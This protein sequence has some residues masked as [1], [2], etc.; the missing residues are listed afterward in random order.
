MRV[1]SH[2]ADRTSRP[3]A[4]TA[5]PDGSQRARRRAA[6]GLAVAAV[7]AALLTW[8]VATGGALVAAFDE[9]LTRVTRSWADALGWPVDVAHA[10]GVATAPIRSSIVGAVVVVVLLLV[11]QRAAA[12]WVAL[13]GI[14]GVVT[15]ETVKLTMGRQR[16]P[17]AAQ[18]EDDLD[19]SFPSG[20][21]MVG[22]YLYLVIGLV[23]VQMGRAR[24]RGWLVGIGWSLVAIG[25]LIGASRLVLGV[26]WP[27]DLL[28][29]WAFGSVVALAS[30]LVLWWPLDRGWSRPGD[31]GVGQSAG[32]QRAPRT[33]APHQAPDQLP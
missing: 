12:G 21:A 29:G 25:P 24:G 10:I 11:R 1:V 27:T 19:K 31:R 18:F 14:A 4:A 30:A 9:A 15:S 13:S 16:P 20:H 6:L 26:H 8:A 3:G 5:H 23:L 2:P 7:L 32:A 17:G 28:A 22:I 33:A